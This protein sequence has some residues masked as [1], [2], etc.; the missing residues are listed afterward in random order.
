MWFRKA[1]KGNAKSFLLGCQ[2]D[3]ATFVLFFFIQ[4]ILCLVEVLG[5][6]SENTK[7]LIVPLVVVWLA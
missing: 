7:V 6:K 4:L 3:V 2:V 1:A 5:T